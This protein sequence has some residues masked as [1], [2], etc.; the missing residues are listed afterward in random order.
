MHLVCGVQKRFMR[1]VTLH[2]L[3]YSKHN[4]LTEWHATEGEIYNCTV[5]VDVI[6]EHKGVICILGFSYE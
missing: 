1:Q 3:K 5:Q 4:T 6:C 2:F